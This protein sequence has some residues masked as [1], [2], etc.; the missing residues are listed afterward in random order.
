MEDTGEPMVWLPSFMK[1]PS[2]PALISFTLESCPT[3][4]CESG[5]G[6]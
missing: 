6:K 4:R 2:P 1:E 5:G 3:E